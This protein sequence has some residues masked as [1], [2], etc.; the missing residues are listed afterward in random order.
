MPDEF[1]DPKKLWQ[2]Q[3][4]EAIQMS[5]QSLRRRAQELQTK[6]RL[7]A[8]ALMAIGLVLAIVFA[9][10]L[11]RSQ[12]QLSRIGFGVL[13]L[14][15]LY[16]VYQ[17]YRRM[18]PGSIAADAAWSNSLDFYRGELERRRDYVRD[19]WRL[20]VLW[21]FFIGLALLILPMLIAMR[22]NP[23]LLLNAV[24][25]LVLLV[26]WFVAFF[27]IRKRDQRNLQAEIDE[28]KALAKEG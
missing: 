6:S 8:L 21:L 12:N 5:L 11:G 7:A 1:K 10:S 19:I 13:S 2:D 18:W 3:P 4:M 22:A 27:F 26:V 17:V 15:A 25:F 28:L 14:W 24:P 9:V 16:G 20:S 23:R